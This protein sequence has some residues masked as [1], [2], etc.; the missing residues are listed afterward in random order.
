MVPIEDGRTEGVGDLC[1]DEN[2]IPEV[3]QLG[4]DVVPLLEGVSRMDNERMSDLVRLL[5]S[6]KVGYLE[7]W[8]I[9][10]TFGGK[11]HSGF[12]R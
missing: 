6:L 10:C 2:H 4:K 1:R 12:V 5:R 8:D 7:W 11:N 3:P 9:G